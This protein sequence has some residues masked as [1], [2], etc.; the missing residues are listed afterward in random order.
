MDF[1]SRDQYR[2]AVEEIARRSPGAEEDVA[3]LAVQL[4]DN[5]ARRKS[6]NGDGTQGGGRA[7]H[8][9]YFLVGRGRRILEQ[10]AHVRFSPG[11]LLR[12]FGRRFALPIYLGSIFLTTMALV[13]RHGVRGRH[14]TAWDI[15][16][17][18]AWGV[19]LFICT[20]QLAVA[21]VHWAAMQLAHPRIL[22]RMDFSKGIPA[23]HRTIV[24]VPTII[25]DKQDIDD[26]VEALEVRFWPI[27]MRTYALRC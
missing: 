23:A 14:A 6:G 9:G 16:G 7:T 15:G 19:L 17:L 18:A 3:R 20:S 25:T 4:A 10:S 24:A 8:V 21:L 11:R 1:A 22:P 2:H 27:E 13:G 26:L 12:Q 5:H